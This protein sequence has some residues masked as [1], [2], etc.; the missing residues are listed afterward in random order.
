MSAG[1]DRRVTVTRALVELKTLDKRITKA[2]AECDLI[3]V[4]TRDQKWDVNEYSRKAQAAYQSATDLIQRRDVLK[5]KVLH[6]NSVTKVRIG[7]HEYTVTEVIDRKQSLRYRK[8][9]LER[10]RIQKASAES[11]HAQRSDE[12]KQKLDRLLEVNLGGK[13][14]KGHA[15]NVGSISKAY[16]DANKVDLIDPI[17][18]AGKIA[19]L[20]EAVTLFEQEADLVLSESNARTFLE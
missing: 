5:A 11:I 19:A 2:I 15:E 14:G 6:S 9:L 10:L 18:I 17:A 20:E 8:S 13:D 4:R 7:E 1:E 12:V 16:Y 3:K